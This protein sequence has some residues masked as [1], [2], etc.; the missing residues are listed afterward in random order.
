[1]AIDIG[2]ATA[3][4]AGALSFLSPC[5]LPLVPP[6]LCYMA[7]VSVEDF[8]GDGTQVVSTKRAA[9][10]GASL[11]FVL[12]FTTVFVALGAGATTIGQFLRA[13]QEPLAI[14]AGIVIILMGLNFLGI[15]RIP[16]LSREARFQS[17]ARPA[18]VVGAYL[19]GLAFA[20]GW[21]P[22]IG[23][24]LGPILTLAGGRGTVA[25]GALL[26][27]VYSLGLGIPFLIAALFSGAFMR[28][29]SRFRVHLGR[30]EKAIGGLL[31]IAGVLFL[32]GGMQASAYWIL[33]TF[34]ALQKLG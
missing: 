23:P 27:A 28:F 22:C 13:W 29:L 9:L 25:D 12:G 7:G 26:L 18:T 34:P 33:E 24:V 14:A 16:L 17:N 8:R 4:G 3:L 10:L 5:V 19:M 20:F 6:Y 21:T 15:L 31:V 1:M 30:V 2:Y 11:A 32:T